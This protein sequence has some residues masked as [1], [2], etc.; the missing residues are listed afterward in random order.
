MARL[1]KSARTAQRARDLR[2][3][4]THCEELLWSLL[5]DR[6]LHEVKFRRQVPLGDYVV[7]FVCMG[8][9][10]IVELDGPE[11][12]KPERKAFDEARTNTLEAAGFP[13]L[14]IRNGDLTGDRNA[15][16]TSIILALRH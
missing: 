12:Q 13:V 10:L 11:H 2:A 4:Q 9:K 14:R 15:V 5:R 6:R 7:D 1:V 16:L 3:D 8:S